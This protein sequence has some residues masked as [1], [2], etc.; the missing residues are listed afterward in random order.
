MYLVLD[1][2]VRTL[3]A[4]FVL[5]GDSVRLIGGENMRRVTKGLFTSFFKQMLKKLDPSGVLILFDFFFL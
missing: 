5:V 3:A 4:A 1:S 2:G